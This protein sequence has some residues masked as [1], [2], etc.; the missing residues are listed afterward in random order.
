MLDEQLSSGARRRSV[1]EAFIN[2]RSGCY[3]V[4]SCRTGLEAMEG[5]PS[6]QAATLEMQH[7]LLLKSK[8][9]TGSSTCSTCLEG[10]SNAG[11]P[12]I[13]SA[14]PRARDAVR[15]S[16]NTCL[17]A[18]DRSAQTARHTFSTVLPAKRR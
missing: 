10:I 3:A 11:P 4:G 9:H 1:G 14:M 7:T 6:A 17:Q 12:S 2:P 5:L 15:F 8:A 16:P 13:E 18:A